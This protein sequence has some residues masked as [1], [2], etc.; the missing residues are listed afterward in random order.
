MKELLLDCGEGCTAICVY[1]KATDCTL[2]CV[3]FMTYNIYL[4]KAVEKCAHDSQSEIV[5]ILSVTEVNIRSIDFSC[6]ANVFMV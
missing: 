3:S 4:N 6:A 2:K 1:S 5:Q